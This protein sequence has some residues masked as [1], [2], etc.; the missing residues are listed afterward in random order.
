MDRTGHHYGPHRSQVGDLWL[1]PGARSRVPVVVLIHGGFWRGLVNRRVMHR[2]ASAITTRG[3]AAWNIEYRRVGHGGGGWPATF[4]DVAAA[5]DF[6]TGVE[7]VDLDR[8]ITC[9]HSAGG[10]LAL[11]VA[12]PDRSE[13]ADRSP[14]MAPSQ[15]RVN[16]AVALA[17]ISDL[18]AVV[19]LLGGSAVT[20]SERLRAVSPVAMLPLGVPQVLVHGLA[21][22]VVPF[23]MS[24]EYAR[25]AAEAGDSVT[26]VPLAG[27]THRDLIRAPSVAWDAIAEQMTALFA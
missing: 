17:G 25:R 13:F 23:Q 8:V 11:W 6:L 7:S 21:D 18:A 2:L 14:G 19:D 16:G 22:Q 10:Q 5:V 3:W 24:E 1:P 9:G 26:Y 20:R 12:A 4:F 27:L 15:V